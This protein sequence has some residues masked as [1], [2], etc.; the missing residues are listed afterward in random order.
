MV[1]GV[2]LLATP[3]VAVFAALD[4]LRGDLEGMRAYFGWSIV[5]FAAYFIAKRLLRSQSR[6]SGANRQKWVT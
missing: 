4:L 6:G 3:V 2:V 5:A 1:V